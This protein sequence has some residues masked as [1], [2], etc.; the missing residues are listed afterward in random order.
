M[1]PTRRTREMIVAVIVTVAMVMGLIPQV[2]NPL[3]AAGPP[4][5]SVTIDGVTTEHSSFINGDTGAWDQTRRAS[6]IGK[7]ITVKLLHDVTV[8]E[9][10]RVVSGSEIT[11]DLNGFAIDRGLNYPVAGGRVIY[12][13]SSSHLTITD[14]SSTDIA[15]QGKITGGYS[16]GGGAG[17][18][19]NGSDAEHPSTLTITGGN[20]TN[21]VATSSTQ[22]AD[23]GAI[24]VNQNAN[25]IMTGGSI[26]DNVSNGNGGGVYLAGTFTMS[27]GSITD[28]KANVGKDIIWH[29]GGGVYVALN[30]SFTVSGAVNITDNHND[31]D[32]KD[33]N[34]K[35]FNESTHIDVT[36]S[37]A[38]ASI[39][40]HIGRN[41]AGDGVFT[42]DYDAHNN[43]VDPTTIFTADHVDRYVQWTSDKH[44][45]ELVVD[46]RPTLTYDANGG[47]GTVATQKAE[48]GTPII[49]SANGFTKAGHIFLGW[50]DHPMNPDP[51]ITLKYAV[52]KSLLLEAEERFTLYAKWKKLNHDEY[53]VTYHA[54]GGTGD[55]ASQITKVGTDTT[56]S[57]NGFT[58]GGKVFTGWNTA[59]DGTGTAYEASGMVPSQSEGTV[60]NLYAQWSDR[61]SATYTVTY[62]ANGGTGTVASQTTNVETA[63]TVSAN[64]FTR[65]GY[66]FTGWNT[67]AD[68][69]GTAYAAGAT[70]PSQL[71]GTTVTLY[72]QWEQSTAST[73][74]ITG[75]VTE[76]TYGPAAG[77]S[78]KLMKG[79]LQIGTQ[80]VTTGP[81]GEFTIEDVPNGIYNLVIA[82]T[83]GTTVTV[84]VEIV[85]HDY[86]FEEAI[87]LPPGKTSSLVEVK[88]GTPDIVVGNLDSQFDA[89]DKDFALIPNHAVEIKLIAEKKDTDQVAT[90]ATKITAVAS[91][92][93]IG[94]YLDLSVT[95]IKT[96][97][98]ATYSEE[99]MRTL[100]DIVEII[101][102]LP[103]E[104][105][106][107]DGLTVYRV[108]NGTAAA[109]PNG[110]A[111]A[112]D[113]EYYEVV[114]DDIMIH[115]KRFSTYAIGYN[116]PTPPTTPGS[117]SSRGGA[118]QPTIPTI[119]VEPLED[120]D[121]IV[122]KDAKKADMV[123][124]DGYVIADVIVD[125]KSIGATDT[126]T[127]TDN[128]DHNISAV[129]VK[130]MALPYYDQDGENIYI[131]FSAIHTNLY[132]YIAPD[133][134][135]VEFEENPKH[136]TDNTIA[137][138]K[139]SIDFV[140]EREIFAGT[141]QH[142][143]SPNEA[144]TRAMFVAVIGRLYER[145]YGHVAG[146]SAFLDVDEESYYAK[147]VAWAHETGIIKGVGENKFAPEEKVTREQMAVILRNFATFLEKGNVEGETLAY[148]DSASI[149]TWAVD[150]A[151]YTQETNVITGRDGNTFAPQ[152]QATR[153]EVAAVMERFINT[154]VK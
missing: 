76:A 84:K 75:T 119:T 81:G 83:D 23:G 90:D 122:S 4:V 123:P 130:A 27:G 112:V 7:P 13:E 116:T 79:K 124:K 2:A 137:W 95:K 25:L 151:A 17:I 92:Q 152:E 28:N 31:V 29:G 111:N 71:E 144:M 146:T 117:G 85:G 77:A 66:T 43:G 53:A 48:V 68:G 47:T 60:V 32:N 100:P 45:A 12:M 11:I 147:Y 140:T 52:G 70:V 64:G 24:Y 118:G 106:G 120:G 57:A 89:A 22:L 132:K 82:H 69:T 97:T 113:G 8:D 109:L 136:F 55:V 101:V 114:G 78:V 80:G 49:I 63:T 18:F 145:S 34:V 51:N 96:V 19:M 148:S 20:I 135:I 35:L 59:A 40:V 128:H 129:F 30:A 6:N 15:D 14:S 5:A 41:T 127:F 134:V 94:V 65:A 154:I 99:T 142:T 86:T 110:S 121:I 62:D 26:T 58:N 3:L 39:G 67:A 125:G 72:A 126:Y 150:G 107:K 98:G 1:K 91:Q 153:A 131:G 141:A 108:H 74:A 139:P 88:A 105:T 50:T 138:A 46:P 93:T 54:N 87:S 36:G 102:P 33:D 115:T 16:T 56:V 10:L 143:F 133:G 103:S 73:H 61:P 9:E 21:N 44:E 37:L 149:S 42:T 38:D 104:L